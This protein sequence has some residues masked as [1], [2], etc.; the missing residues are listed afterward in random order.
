VSVAISILIREA[1]EIFGQFY[2][3]PMVPAVMVTALFASRFAVLL[4]VALSIAA[5][6]LLVPRADMLDAA[7]NAALFTVVALSI[8]AVCRR[9]I[10][11]IADARTLSRNLAV[12]E[13]LLDAILASVPV[14][15]L[16][17]DGRVRRITSAAADLL[18]AEP[19]EILGSPF[20][21]FVP[22]FDMAAVAQAAAQGGVLEPPA[23]GHWTARTAQGDAAPLT[24]HADTLPDHIEPEHIV[25]SLADQR[26]A[27]AV[28]ERE[29]DLAEQLSTVWR[30]NSMGEMAATLA[31]E[32]NQPL[33]AATVYL[34]A[35]QTDIARVGPVGD[36]AGRAIDLA[37]TQLLRAGEIIRRMRDLISSGARSF[38]EEGAAAMI[39]DLAPVF[40]LISRDSGVA[41]QVDMDARDDLVLADRIQIQQAVAN[42]V[43]N[44]VDAVAGRPDALV[45][46]AGRRL[47][48]EGYEILVED[49]GPGISDAQR[50]DMF[51]PMTTT[52]AGGMGLGL[53]VTR[54]IVESHGATLLVGRST[55][56]GASFSF[57]LSRSTELEAA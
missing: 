47:A 11:A 43:R 8:A 38:A 50:D 41:I 31:H 51:R 16:D 29:R 7:A 6:L 13:A 34:H 12:R 39:D 56:G 52:K 10:A 54:S 21:R 55:L 23:A 17:R 22:D 9:L 33:T 32:L 3:L 48:G 40:A 30:L 25:L 42:L 36:S 2:Y 19:D 24:L 4:A 5:N 14:A 45:R 49:N 46:V 53:S 26:Q 27:Q 28:R 15:T 44:G 18:G 57:R 20:Q 37:K 1:L 35:G